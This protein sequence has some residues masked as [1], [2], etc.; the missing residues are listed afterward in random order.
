MGN[1]INILET[2]RSLGEMEPDS[3]DGSYEMV[4]NIIKAYSK[5]LDTVELDH[6]DLDAIYLL[7]IGTWSCSIKV[8]KSRI[9]ESHLLDS[10][11]ERLILLIEDI[12]N[13]T[14]R[15]EYL[16]NLDGPNTYG[17][18]GTGFM[19]F[20]GKIEN[21]SDVYRFINM[22]IK[23]L[24]S[25]NEEEMF[26]LV[27]SVLSEP[28]KGMGTASISEILHCINPKVF[29]VINQN[30]GNKDG[31]FS[32]LGLNLKGSSDTKKYI[33]NCRKIKEFRDKN[34]FFKNYRVLDVRAC[35][36][37]R[38]EIK[39]MSM[40]NRKKFEL[41]T[42]LYGPPGTGKTYNSMIY[43]VAICDNRSL[44]EVHEEPYENVLKRFND[45]KSDG[46]I[47]FTT[48][49]QSYGYEEFIEGIKP[50]LEDDDSGEGAEQILYKVQSGIF[51]K[52]C[53]NAMIPSSIDRVK[54][55]IRENPNL[56]KV[57]LEKTGENETRSFCLENNCIRIGWKSYG[58]QLPDDEKYSGKREL[59]AFYNKMQKG[60]LVLSCF[61]S[62]T[63]DAI[64]VV[65]GD[66]KWDETFENYNR[67]R[68]V[69][70]LVKGIREDI[71]EINSGKGMT[72]PTVYKLSVSIADV[73]KIVDKYTDNS[74]RADDKAYVFIIDEINRGNIS[75][76]F[77]EL[78]TLIEPSKRIGADEEIRVNLPYSG[79][80]E[81]GVP[82]NLYIL[83]TMNTADRSIASIDTALRRRFNFIEMMPDESLL[84]GIEI[85][86]INIK[87]MV[88]KMNK[89][90]TTLF[91][92]DHTLGHAYFLPLKKQ[93]TI[94]KLADIFRNNV[95]PLLQEY[96]YD[97]YEKI[98][99]VLGDNQKK[100]KENQFIIADNE[101][102][103]KLFGDSMF[104]QDDYAIY[105]INEKA[106][107]NRES[108]ISIYENNEA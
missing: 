22:C 47:A 86:N 87:N 85:E 84:E 74:D 68:D 33:E 88:E 5:V 16:N 83:G 38:G 79:K 92:R 67:R 90:V 105:R 41:N 93:A 50:V 28:I 60:D 29:P 57:S 91:D 6:K 58:Q 31:M 7:V 25:N 48:F 82:S 2:L 44:E 73:L 107:Q 96:F 81:F 26:D 37:E 70:W 10:D 18:F 100:N 94:E 99:M 102:W 20:K 35:L 108:Y 55:G 13:R 42:I 39:V 98:R 63:I 46:R 34:L 56:W 49:H 80:A 97:D 15:G 101:D 4:R 78:I 69:N 21:K 3:H 104:E 32:A 17:L 12:W 14:Q 24:E 27:E 1:S 77:G 75:K 103:R 106:F 71:T 61:D 30:V 36:Y 65:T 64:G 53:E 72:L 51:K 40:N 11:K 19:S 95:I 8:K 45:L 9:E 66:A 62:S 89:R 76:I 59:N 52:F 43:A 54:A 23:V